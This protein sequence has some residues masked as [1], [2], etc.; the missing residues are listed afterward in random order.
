VDNTEYRTIGQRLIGH[1]SVPRVE[2]PRIDL[3]D[4][5][6]I[7]SVRS[8]PLSNHPDFY[9]PRCQYRSA[10][11]KGG[12]VGFPLGPVGEPPGGGYAVFLGNE[13]KVS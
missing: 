10:G 8:K 3:R 4:L 6:C 11:N 7:R 13:E 2:I 12:V 5:A 9:R 1:H